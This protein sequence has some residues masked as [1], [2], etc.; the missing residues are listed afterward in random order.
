MRILVISN[1]YPPHVLGG[2][3]LG[4]RDVVDA[5]A[6]RGHSMAVLTSCHGVDGP[7][8]EGDIC[9]WLFTDRLDSASDAGPSARERAHLLRLQL[10]DQ[11]AF[12]RIVKRH[13]PDVIYVWNLA[14]LPI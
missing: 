10:C 1:F 4:C 14:K 8:T 12:D 6:R 11:L 13:K 5:L 3:E 9:R 7:A 2:Y